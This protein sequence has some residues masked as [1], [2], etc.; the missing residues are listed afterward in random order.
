[1]PSHARSPSFLDMAKAPRPWIVSKH[2]PLEKLEENLWVVDGTVPGLPFPRRMS[3]IRRSDGTLLFFNAMPL[4]EPEL[5]E[6]LGWG[7]P[8]TLLVP[9]DQHMIDARAFAEK[10]QLKVY[11]PKL[12]EE[13]ARKR[14]DIAGTFE[15][16][17]ADPN[18]C[19][20]TAAGVKNGE[21][22][23]TLKSPSGHSSVLV[24]D[25]VMNARKE[26]M[27][28]MPRLMGF[29][30]KLRI[31]PVFRLAFLKDK[32][33]LKGQLTTLADLPGLKHLVPSHGDVVSEGVADGLRRAAS[34]L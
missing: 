1:L 31:V 4:A 19:I 7:K 18:L 10:L 27:G 20:E 11:A 22:V 23:L 21:P 33:A 17:P 13:K 8:A 25:I 26:Q 16:V 28:L 30:G 5:E 15:D 3:I 14:A 29:A 32:Q 34:T 24:S 9:H 6:V 12:C 2:G